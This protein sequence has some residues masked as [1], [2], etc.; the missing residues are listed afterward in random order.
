MSLQD[1]L[2]FASILISIALIG[3]ILLRSRVKASAASEWL[4]CPHSPRSGE[5]SLQL[6]IGLSVLWLVV[7]AVAVSVR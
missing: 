5:E 3:I 6:T 2:A 1:G 4:I 7:A